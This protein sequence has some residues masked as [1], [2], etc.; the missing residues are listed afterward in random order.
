M[1]VALWLTKH[2]TSFLCY[3][4]FHGIL[5]TIMAFH[6]HTIDYILD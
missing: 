1:V 5:H 6:L 3:P 4:L 2:V